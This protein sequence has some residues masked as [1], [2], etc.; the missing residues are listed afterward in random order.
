MI[1]LLLAVA[2]TTLIVLGLGTPMLGNWGQFS[3]T[4]V[5]LLIISLGIGFQILLSARLIILRRKNER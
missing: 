2:L 1:S 5:L 3:F 4:L